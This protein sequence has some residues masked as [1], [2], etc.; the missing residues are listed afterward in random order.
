M[1]AL[2]IEEWGEGDRV[3]VLLHGITADSGTWWR[4]GPELARQG[5]RV[6]A[7]DLPGHGRSPRQDGYTLAAMREAVVAAVPERPAL[8]LGHSLGALLLAPLV[9]G[10]VLRPERVVY[11]DPAWN[12]A[13]GTTVTDY[14]R[15]QKD[16]DLEQIQK[17][18]P[19]WPAEAQRGK[20]ESLARW[21]PA[22]LQATADTP[23]YEPAVPA[24][25]VLADPSA[26]IPPDRAGR[27]RDRG[28]E[29]RIVPGTDHVLYIVDHDGFWEALDGWR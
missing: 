14:F 28:F 12:A 4:V 5:Y 8:A 29:V 26:T 6:L 2:H 19:R 13:S 24:L 25:V 23:G 7:P 21:D 22:T 10:A 1:T 27:L 18:L 20:L 15:S 9:D 3:A 17:A 16:W 11:A